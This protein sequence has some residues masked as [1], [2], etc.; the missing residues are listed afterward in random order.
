MAV[1]AAFWKFSN[2]KT[3]SLEVFSVDFIVLLCV[4]MLTHVFC[5]NILTSAFRL[6]NLL[7]GAYKVEVNIVS[8]A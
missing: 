8:F 5:N 2:Y 3:N 7:M 4:I 1:F 6:K